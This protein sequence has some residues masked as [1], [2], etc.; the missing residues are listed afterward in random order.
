MA[1]ENAKFLSY[2]SPIKPAYDFF[3]KNSK[4]SYI[5]YPC[6]KIINSCEIHLPI[7][8]SST[9]LMENLWVKIRM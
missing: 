2:S 8:K 3:E 6:E 4:Y 5:S 1:I 9:A 7:P